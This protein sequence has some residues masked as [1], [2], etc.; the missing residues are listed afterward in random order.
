M[1]QYIKSNKQLTPL[2]VTDY[3]A[4][5]ISESGEGYKF[6]FAYNILKKD[7]EAGAR[8]LKIT[9]YPKNYDY[10]S[11][12]I[13]GKI[14]YA[15]SLSSF[16][17]AKKLKETLVLSNTVNLMIFLTNSIG[18]IDNTPQQVNTRTLS[19]ISPAT[20]E[21]YRNQGSNSTSDTTLLRE[22]M[23]GL[24]VDHRLDP[25][26]A[27]LKQVEKSSTNYTMISSLQNYYLNEALQDLNSNETYYEVT[28][29]D[30]KRQNDERL[31]LNSNFVI[32]AQ[33]VNDELEVNFEIYGPGQS[34]SNYT[35]ITKTIVVS[36]FLEIINRVK[37]KPVIG[38]VGNSFE[39]LEVVQIDPNAKS[40]T[41]QKKTILKSGE[42]SYYSPLNSFV[43]VKQNDIQ[44]VKDVNSQSEIQIYRCVSYKQDISKLSS[45]K[46]AIAGTTFVIDPTVLLL[47]NDQSQKAV[48]IEVMQAPRIAGSVKIQKRRLVSPS[49]F[50]S[51][52]VDV[53]GFSSLSNESYATWDYNVKDGEIYEYKLTYDGRDKAIEFD[54]ISKTH[55]FLNIKNKNISVS[56]TNLSPVFVNNKLEISFNISTQ[57]VDKEANVIKTALDNEKLFEQFKAEFEESLKDRLQEIIFYKLVRVDLNKSPG[58]EEQFLN[59]IPSSN[60][61]NFTDN[62]QSQL[63]SNVAELN[64]FHNY[65]Y[66]LY[67]YY[68]SPLSILRDYTKTQKVRMGDGK[69]KTVY[70][71]PYKWIQP[72]VI[73]KST[74]IAQD[75]DGNLLKPSLIEDGD[76]GIVAE[77]TQIGLKQALQLSTC[78]ASRFDSKNVI[79]NWGVQDVLKNYDHFVI[80]KESGKKR[81]IL[82][83][84]IGTSYVDE[85]KIEDLGTVIYYVIPVFNDYS[86][87]L[88]KK[89]N[90][91]TYRPE[92]AMISEG[93]NTIVS[94]KPVSRI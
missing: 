30:T 71:K 21:F 18:S 84:V 8:S 7:I 76:G 66:Q 78:K 94:A 33:F 50:E 55:K 62:V 51:E 9:I 70:W 40:L 10:S 60:A 2:R 6:N 24:I 37:Q 42:V 23:L 14:A 49:K 47:S 44:N 80:V 34:V 38:A 39:S 79:I 19:P 28:T 52:Y 35:K 68:K 92:E 72:D 67:A 27:I 22:N 65:R 63:A 36:N 59:V 12:K 4:T 45:Y 93:I 48:K 64:P 89:T 13:S 16:I 20:I 90:H 83:T 32:P 43:D 75:V 46:N 3:F 5:L 85:L 31:Y 91:I 87:G 58:V 81:V 86:I 1:L 25:S 88:A 73:N 56:M 26:N 57:N 74:F 54:S 69:E 15:K 77:I 29:K 17:D 61:T 41:V 82:D 11:P 53:V